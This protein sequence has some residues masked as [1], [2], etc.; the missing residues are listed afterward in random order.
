MLWKMKE[1]DNKNKTIH[2]S[3][4]LNQILRATKFVLRNRRTNKEWR[5]AIQ[6]IEK[7]SYFGE[8]RTVCKTLANQISVAW[9]SE[10]WVENG[11]RAAIA[12]S[13]FS[14]RNQQF[15]KVGNFP[16]FG[17]KGHYFR[18]LAPRWLF[19]ALAPF[20]D[21]P[22]AHWGRPTESPR[23]HIRI[24]QCPPFPSRGGLGLWPARFALSFPATFN[25]P[26]CP[27]TNCLLLGPG[28]HIEFCSHFTWLW[29]TWDTGPVS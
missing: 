29:E 25:C 10:K 19:A 28:R 16:A 7:L 1:Q 22:P 26:R 24:C 21:P 17:L 14:L 27:L 23:G 15:L 20:L 11:V 8:D 5:W 12:K 4:Q 2:L 18:L 9:A 6:L 13:I 3:Y